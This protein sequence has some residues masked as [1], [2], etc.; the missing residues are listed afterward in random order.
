MLCTN[1]YTQHTVYS[2]SPS[3]AISYSKE[4]AYS[5]VL[6]IVLFGYVYTDLYTEPLN[7]P[8]LVVSSVLTRATPI[9]SQVSLLLCVREVSVIVYTNTITDTHHSTRIAEFYR[10]LTSQVLAVY[11]AGMC[12][13]VL[14]CAQTQRKHRSACVYKIYYAHNYI[15]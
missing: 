14:C 2:Q 9:N 12:Y 3:P 4:T 7:P 5:E 10:T 8:T 11:F 6:L 1:Y 13:V 15:L